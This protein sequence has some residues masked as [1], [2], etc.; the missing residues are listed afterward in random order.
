MEILLHA[1]EK[2]LVV[3][4]SYSCVAVTLSLTT[5]TI[6]HTVFHTIMNCILVSYKECERCEG[7]ST[8]KM[9]QSH[10]SPF[11]LVHTLL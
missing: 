8:E 7:F 1:V 9:L 5:H 10:A 6:L 4:A 3:L 2:M 11:A